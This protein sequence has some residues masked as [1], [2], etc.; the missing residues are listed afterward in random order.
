M[1]N[2]LRNNIFIVIAI[3]L[4]LI[5]FEI[6]TSLQNTAILGVGLLLMVGAAFVKNQTAK[7]IL[8]SAGFF[9]I[10]LAVL[11]TRS[12]WMMILAMILLVVLYRTPEGNEF[13][14]FGESMLHPFQIKEQY[15]G[16]QLVRP[17][18]GQRSL[19]KSQSMFDSREENKNVYEWDDINLV[20]FGGNSIID[21]GNTI[22]PR[23]E[24]IVLIRKVFGRT[25]VIIPKGLGLRL[26]VSAIS[27][28]VSFES[29]QYLLRGDNFQWTSPGYSEADRKLKVLITIV[30]GDI[31]VILL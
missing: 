12:I 15:H 8:L 3:S 17:Q 11:V 6:L 27:G 28:Q 20:Y 10:L 19:L 26:N 7:R 13:F 31:E 24:N 21:L 1:L 4:L 18:S 23:G 14:F 22:L 2:F 16:I 5:A 30:T 29:Q 9:L 25:R